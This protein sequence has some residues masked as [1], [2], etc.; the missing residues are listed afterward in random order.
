[1]DAVTVTNVTKTFSD[2]HGVEKVLEHVSFSLEEGSFTALAGISGAG[3]TTIMHLLAG[4]LKPDSGEIC[5]GGKDI[6]HFSETEA[7]VF[8]RRHIAVVFQDPALLPGL[9]VEENIVLPVL[10]DTGRYLDSEK[11]EEILVSLS[12]TE[13][14]TRYPR[15][16]SGG[17]KQKVVFARAL[18]S[19]A[20]LILADEPTA[21]LDTRQSLEIAGMLKK[22]ANLYHRTVLMATHDL[23]LAQIC[24]HI[25]E[26]KDGCVHSFG[27][28]L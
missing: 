7:S 18:F 2:P 22:C 8:R 23:K 26:I 10:L 5:V 13:K 19:D 3:K 14:K 4:L 11:L 28:L 27:E 16:L 15:E 21:R 20:E 6:Q 24:D 1:M 17:E 12:L 25:L 9:T